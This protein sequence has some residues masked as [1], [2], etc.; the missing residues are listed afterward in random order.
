MVGASIKGVTEWISGQEG[1]EALK[2]YLA[3]RRVRSFKYFQEVLHPLLLFQIGV[4]HC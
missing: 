1:R 2:G 3:C 4:L